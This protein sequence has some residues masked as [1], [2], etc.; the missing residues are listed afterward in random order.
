MFGI[1]PIADSDEALWDSMLNVNVK[2]TYF[3]SRAALP[4]LKKA[5]GVI[6]NVASEAGLIGAPGMTVY[7]HP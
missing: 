3:V 7:C 5:G 6:V 4:A 2:G 1:A